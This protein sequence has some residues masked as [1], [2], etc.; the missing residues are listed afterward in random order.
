MGSADWEAWLEK[1]LQRRVEV[2]YGRSRTMPL[3]IE[4]ADGRLKVRMHRFFEAAPDDVRE[5]MAR[6]ITVGRRARKACALLD[7]WIDARLAE[8]PRPTIVLKPRGIVH[9]LASMAD[10]LFAREFLV[11][12]GAPASGARERPGVTWGRRARSSARRTLGIACFG[13]DF[14]RNSSRM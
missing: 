12:F 9:D 6:W 7:G 3:Q 4:D 1:R 11:D 2:A 13:F 8:L 14:A 10:A 5:S